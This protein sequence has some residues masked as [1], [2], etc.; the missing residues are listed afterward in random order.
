MSLALHNRTQHS[1]DDAESSQEVYLGPCLYSGE[2]FCKARCLFE[3]YR[4]SIYVISNH[5]KRYENRYEYYF[6]EKNI[7]VIHKNPAAIIA[8][9]CYRCDGNATNIV[10]KMF[11][12]GIDSSRRAV[13]EA[14]CLSSLKKNPSFPRYY[15]LS[16]R[17]E[18]FSFNILMELIPFQNLS[19]QI[20][21]GNI[22]LDDT[23]EI[24]QQLIDVLTYLLIRNNI[25]GD[26]KTENLIWDADKGKLRVIDVALMHDLN[27]GNGFDIE[28]DIQTVFYRSPEALLKTWFTGSSD[29]WSVGCVMYEMITGK[30]L[31]GIDD[32]D[33]N[34][35]LQVVEKIV[36]LLGMPP[37]DILR[38]G[39]DTHKYFTEKQ[40]GTW[41]LKHKRVN[42]NPKTVRQLIESEIGDKFSDRQEDIEKFIQIISVILQYNRADPSVVRNLFAKT[43]SLS[44]RKILEENPVCIK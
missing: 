28:Y 20:Q 10:I 39:K 8:Y 27:D 36:D 3:L 19:D 31:F 38:E 29:M 34:L 44:E 6:E 26:V 14:H 30:V 22:D 2:D 7:L 23:I 12:P 37:D 11:A 21:N 15:G 9:G 18:V 43:F 4:E 16:S 41:E 33:S 32:L 42:A 13:R 1:F 40:D 25:H 35:E 5:M 24:T 17:D